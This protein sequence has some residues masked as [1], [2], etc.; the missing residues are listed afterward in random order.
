LLTLVVELDIRGPARFLSHAD[1][2]RALKR[3]CVRAQLNL[4]YSQGFN[5]RPKM[6]IPLPKPV[7]MAS[8]GD[9]LCVRLQQQSGEVPDSR[10][11]AQMLQALD[12]QLPSGMTVRTLHVIPGK[13]TLYPRAFACTFSLKTSAA[14]HRAE[15]KMPDLMTRDR[16]VIERLN[17]KKPHKTK[18]IDIR[19]FISSIDIA[20]RKLCMNCLVHDTGTIRVEEMLSSLGLD[21]ADLDGPVQRDH[22]A[23]QAH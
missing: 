19:P 13:I 6:S 20:P 5:P 2:Q 17:P 11:Q 23:W 12:A 9:V 16:F 7:G 18:Q 10:A 22:L 3:C 8:L 21:R 15:A 14:Q 4:R 1:L